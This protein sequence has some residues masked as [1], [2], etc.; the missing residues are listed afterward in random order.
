MEC[1]QDFTAFASFDRIH[2]HDGKIGILRHIGKIILIGSSNPT[3]SINLDVL[4]YFAGGVAYL[5]WEVDIPCRKYIVSDETVNGAFTDHN[6]I[7]VGGTDVVDGLSLSNKRG[8]NGI[9]V[10]DLLFR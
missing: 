8:D 9:K 1:K 6:G 10:F 4:S 3:G 5:S 7:F 2:F